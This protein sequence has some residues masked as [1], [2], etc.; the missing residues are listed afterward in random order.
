MKIKEIIN[1]LE[2]LAPISSQE[3][4]DNSGLIVGDANVE[5]SKVL[6]SLDCIEATVD[7]AIARKCELIIAH[8]PIVFKGLKRLNGANYIERTVIKAIKND[9]AIYAIH[10]NL[11]NYRFGVNYEIGK[12]IGLNNVRVLQPKNEVLS[13]LICYIPEDHKEKVSQAMFEAGAGKIGDY[14]ECGFSTSGEGSFRPNEAAKPFIGS[15]GEQSKVK[16]AKFEVVCS[17]HAINNVVGAMISA[18]PYEEVAYEIFPMLNSNPYEGSGM[19]GELEKPMKSEKFLEYIKTT[20]NCGAIR[21]TDFTTEYIEKVAYCGGAGSFLL[22]A[23]K[24]SGADI[25]ITG[26]FKYHEFFDADGGII[27]A[28]IGHFESEQ[29]TSHRLAQILTEKF[30]TFAVHLTEVNTNPINYF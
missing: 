24:R 19:V 3:S 21:H 27:I 29:Y 28:D 17:N 20:F 9:I 18:H 2:S 10:T 5:V 8:H 16:E 6:I 4:Y 22:G 12:R 13:K 25:F 15:S 26:D 14:D 23:A 11:D 1:Y 30:V 7:E